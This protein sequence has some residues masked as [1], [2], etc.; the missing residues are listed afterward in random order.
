MIQRLSHSTIYVGDQD[1][2]KEFYVDKLGFDLKMDM[3]AGTFRWL[4][5]SPK[6]Q[7]D[8]ELILMPI[9]QM[10]PR[11]EAACETLKQQLQLGNMPTGVFQT[12]DCQRT[13]E[14]LTAKGVEFTMPPTDRFYGI[15]AIMKDPFGNWYSVTQ[16]KPMPQS[17]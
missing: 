13:F 14:E 15:E 6:G 1:K 11:D 8:L 10:G 2:A 12:A 7:P 3:V 17:A 9:L 4:T 5:V 16:P